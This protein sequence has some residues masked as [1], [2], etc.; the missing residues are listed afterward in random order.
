M[1]HQ[2]R[3]ARDFRNV[4]GTVFLRFCLQFCDTPSLLSRD[5]I[6]LNI[7]ALVTRFNSIGIVGDATIRFEPGLKLAFPILSGD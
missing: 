6:L 1:R 5:T 4:C 2:H 7:F 3:P